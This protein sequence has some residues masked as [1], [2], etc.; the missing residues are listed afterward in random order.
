MEL[1]S[2]CSSVSWSSLHISDVNSCILLCATLSTDR[3]D[4]LHDVII[5]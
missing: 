2:K 5:L 1:L 3:F 4:K